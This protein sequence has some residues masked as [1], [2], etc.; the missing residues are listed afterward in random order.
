MR[1]K[2]VIHRIVAPALGA[3]LRLTELRSPRRELAPVQI[4]VLDAFPMG[5]T[6]RTVFNVAE[7][8]S[9]HHRVEIV[10]LFRTGDQ[11]FFAVPRGVR[12]RVLHDAR[13]GARP[14]HP[15][16]RLL[17]RLPS[18]LLH[19]D[20]IPYDSYSLLSDLK[21]LRCVRSMRGGI[22]ISTRAGLN[23]FVARFAPRSVLT[24]GQEHRNI[25]HHKPELRD[26]LRRTYGRLDAV[27]VLTQA[28]RRDYEPLL[29]RSRA[30]LVDIPNA[31]PPLDGKPQIE[32]DPV[33]IA[34]GRLVR[35][36]GFDLLIDAFAQIADQQPAWQL[37]IYGDGVS[38]RTLQRRIADRGLEGRAVLKG[39]T[40]ALGEAMARASIYAL[41]SRSEGFGMVMVEAMSKGTAV[42]SFDC[43]RGPAEILRN[44]RDGVLVPA[45]DVEALA[46]AL[47]ELMSDD[48]RRARLA[49]AALE[50][51][52]EYELP[53]VAR[54]WHQL[55]GAL[56][57]R[58]V[59]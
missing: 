51:S 56:D 43:P 40:P 10:S 29:A 16:A 55:F 59:A 38:R 20:D 2:L 39:A 15:L 35:D 41:S 25:L 27:A 52:R 58:R 1:E 14:H 34:A 26:E 7:H 48:A 8:L 9:R 47:D 33:V 53:K 18:A 36:K 5:G 13:P 44:G 32:R 57:A 37:H 23:A 22:L 49:A 17:N 24:I 6:N 45:E 19:P 46:A 31:L 11:P 4:L 21:L 50:R 12:V 54:Q 30:T 42:V 28:D 3:L